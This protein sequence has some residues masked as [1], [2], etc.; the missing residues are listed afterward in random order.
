MGARREIAGKGTRHALSDDPALP[1]T[2]TDHRQHQFRVEAQALT[3][4]QH[5][6]PGREV[7]PGQQVVHQFHA[8]AVAGARGNA[9]TLVGQHSQHRLGT[10]QHGFRAGQ[11]H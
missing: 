6:G 11:H 4:G 1:G 8:R 10:R 5:L 3:H 7:D 9:E 2:G